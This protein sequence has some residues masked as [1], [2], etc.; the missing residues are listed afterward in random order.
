MK[1]ISKSRQP[2]ASLAHKQ[3]P[4]IIEFEPIPE[5]FKP[6]GKAPYHMDLKDVIPA[7]AYKAIGETGRLAFHCVG[8]TGGVKRPEAQ[9]MVASGMEHSLETDRM[10]PVFCYHLGDVVYYTGEVAEYWPQFYE[11]YEHY[12]LPIVAIPGNHDGELTTR[13][14]ISLLGFYENFLAEAPDTFT[15]ESHDSGRPAMHQPWF[16]WTLITPFATIIGLYTN[17]PEHGKISPEQRAWFHNEMKAADKSK[18]VIVA[19]HHPVYSFDK[20]HSGSS[21]MATELQDAINT[22]RRV[23]N[24]VLTAHVHNY[25]RIEKTIGGHSIP[26]F[27]IGNGGYWNLHYLASQ[28][29]YTDPET[30]AKL[31]QAIDSRHGFMTFELSQ[32]VINGHF[33]T[34]PRPQESWSD[35]NG[36]N[37]KFDVFSYS[38]LPMFLKDGE[39]AELLPSDGSHVEPNIG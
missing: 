10:H 8:D 34:V 16:Y 11:P 20:Y 31:I 29:G 22:S 13:E 38:A 32:K 12:P 19:L 39:T 5:D 9:A 37:D 7:A 23:P 2:G 1:S 25:Q 21:T 6:R 36:Y 28:P 33:T 26:F 30:G 17:V 3:P 27:V 24:M 14:S 15:H 18:A 35:P 4:R